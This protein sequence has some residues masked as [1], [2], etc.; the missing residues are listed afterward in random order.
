MNNLKT[1]SQSDINIQEAILQEKAR[2]IPDI[3][4][5][6]RYGVSFHYI[7]KLITEKKGINISNFNVDKEIKSFYPK[8][9]TEEK[10]TV[11][12]FKSRGNWATH[13]GEYRGNWSPY[14][15]RNL[16]LRYSKE[17]ETVLDYFCGAG[18]TAVESKLLRR[19]CIALDINK[20]A[21]KL[22]KQNV[23]FKFDN[24]YKPEFLVGDARDLSNLTNNSIDLICAHPPYAN[25]LNYTS[26]QKDDLSNLDIDEFLKEIKKVAEESYRVLKPGRQCA[27]LI[28]D[29]RRKKCVIPLGFQ[30]IDVYLRAGFKLKELIIKRQHN[31]KTSGFWYANSIKYNFLL[32]AHEHLP[33]FEKPIKKEQSIVKENT[34]VYSGNETTIKKIHLKKKFEELET[35]T[36]WNFPENEFEKLLTKNVFERYKN[37]LFIKFPIPEEIQKII[38]EKI[39]IF[40]TGNFCVI[41]TKDVRINGYIRPI[42]K[43]IIDNLKIDTLKI[44]EIIIVNTENKNFNH[45]FP[46]SKELKITHQYL[47]V[48]EKIL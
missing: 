32:L 29:T 47:L 28:G 15:P 45:Q 18:T 36:V 12:S 44:K 40:K 24:T 3:E 4:I 30:F 25:I 38:S 7:E 9:F 16:I 14:I 33:I 13:S 11:W 1:I 26:N 17:G 37:P 20:E 48:Y 21:I 41:Q 42:A 22:A 31:C 2:G 5:G 35:T 27:I 46:F 34:F 19:K 43:E 6:R 23:N 39:F 8:N 10:T